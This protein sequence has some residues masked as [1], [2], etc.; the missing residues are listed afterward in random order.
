MPDS[1][2]EKLKGRK[3]FI[4]ARDAGFALS[5]ECPKP[6]QLIISSTAPRR[7]GVY[8]N[9]SGRA[10]DARDCAIPFGVP[11]PALI[12]TGAPELDHPRYVA[13]ASRF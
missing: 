13:K 4:V 7:H 8:S 6:K 9:G 12:E 5:T 10:R 1:P 3:R 11:R 2:P